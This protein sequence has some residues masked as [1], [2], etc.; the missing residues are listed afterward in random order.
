MPDTDHLP[1]TGAKA[2]ILIGGRLLITLRDDRP[3]I[4]YPNL[5]DLP[6]GGREGDETPEQT[7][8][9]EV[10]EEVGLVL[11]P[12]AVIWKRAFP[13][14]QGGATIGWFFVIRLPP[15]AMQD[16][17]FGDEGQGWAL[18]PPATFLA[19][20]DAVP[21]LQVRLSVWM[22]ETLPELPSVRTGTIYNTH[23]Q[24]D[25]QDEP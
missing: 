25:W 19:R 15:D 8:F 24:R 5:W 22:T 9:R 14:D 20:R 4:P 16:I 17:V 18:E 1:F 10:R 11:D 13:S 2:A 3:D 12:S 21:F 7:L 6:G 23:D